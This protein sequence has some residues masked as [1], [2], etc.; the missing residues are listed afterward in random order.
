MNSTRTFITQFKLVMGLA[1]CSLVMVGCVSQPPTHYYDLTTL[2]AAKENKVSADVTLGI[3]PVTLPQILDRPGVVSHQQATA[4]NVASY[5]IWAGEL[6]PSFTRVL[7]ESIATTL[8][9]EKIW[10][11][12][13]DNRFRPEYQLRV[14][15]DRFSGEL[16]GPVQLSLSWTLLGDFGQQV[17]TTQ[18]YRAQAISGKGYQHYV[19]TLNQLLADFAAEVSLIMV[20]KLPQQQ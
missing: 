16:N 4:V 14:F 3:G 9:H 13:W 11:T 17:I 19:D 2:A 18:R 20:E 7:T 12:P 5:H 15:V 10:A 1:F 6:E 8:Q